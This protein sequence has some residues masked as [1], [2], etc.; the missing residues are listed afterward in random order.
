MSPPPSFPAAVAGHSRTTTRHSREGGN[1]QPCTPRY[2]PIDST[3]QN[4]EPSEPPNAEK[5][6]WT[7]SRKASPS[8]SA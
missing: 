3:D 7:C 4:D 2:T 8:S 6:S 1:L 5:Q